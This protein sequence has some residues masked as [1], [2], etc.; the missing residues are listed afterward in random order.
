MNF[1]DRIL[2]SAGKMDI[3]KIEKQLEKI[4]IEYETI[5]AGY[6]IF[7]D[8]FVFTDKRLILIDKQG[9]SGRKIEYHSIPYKNIR[10]FSIETAGTFDRYSE[11]K[12]W[13]AGNNEPVVK[14]F[15]KKSSDIYELQK[16]LAK[17]LFN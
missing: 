9:I 7:R 2:G 14:K 6:N 11:L 8:Y 16:I 1:I 5:E 12:L 4:T 13:I 10:H 15:S 3:E 17:Y